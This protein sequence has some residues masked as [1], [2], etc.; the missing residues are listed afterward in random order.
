MTASLLLFG[1]LLGVKHALEA[2]HVAAVASLATRAASFHEHVRLAGLWGIGHALTLTAVGSVVVLFGLSLP[3]SLSL[4]LEGTVGVVLVALGVDVLR[5]LRRKRVH[6]HVHRHDDGGPAHVHAHAHAGE[7][8][9]DTRH[10]HQHVHGVGWRALL[11]GTMHGLAGSAALVLL[12]VG[13]TRSVGHALV[14]LVIFG[15]GSIVGMLSLSLAISIP[16]RFSARGFGRLHSGL[17][18]A[19]G[20]AT[21]VLGCWITLHVLT[22]R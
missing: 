13:E 5:R 17:E 11:V 7:L 22:A 15:L 21:I 9:H 2:D 16:L 6:I 8:T 14:Y 10:R 1:F 19:L 3:P 20:T 12:A 18:G 4:A